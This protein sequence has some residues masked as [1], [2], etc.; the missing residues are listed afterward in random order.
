MRRALLALTILLS[1]IPL[2]QA[3]D[4]PVIAGAAV[5][6][7]SISVTIAPNRGQNVRSCAVRMERGVSPETEACR[8]AF[9]IAEDQSTGR[10]R[11]IRIEPI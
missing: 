3:G 9:V 1:W 7:V 4:V 10:D 11:S 2:V 6:T 8:G 5:A